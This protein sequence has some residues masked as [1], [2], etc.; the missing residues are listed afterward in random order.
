MRAAVFT[1]EF[2]DSTQC[3][4]AGKTLRGSLIELRDFQTIEHALTDQLHAASAKNE[5]IQH[6]VIALRLAP[7]LLEQPQGGIDHGQEIGGG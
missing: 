7:A 4:C 6:P 1:D 2:L 3:L 5:R